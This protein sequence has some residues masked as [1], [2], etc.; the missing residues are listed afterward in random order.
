VAEL[1]WLTICPCLGMDVRHVVVVASQVTCAEVLRRNDYRVAIFDDPE[2]AFHAASA[3]GVDAI[4][5][6]LETGHD[7]DRRVALAKRLQEDP[8]TREVPVVIAITART[9]TA[10]PG[11]THRFGA[12]IVTMTTPNCAGFAEVLDQILESRT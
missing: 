3:L 5:I 9:E 2:K 7:A 4:V 11:A 10:P 8:T 1:P 6:H 12:A